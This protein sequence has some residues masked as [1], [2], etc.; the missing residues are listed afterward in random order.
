MVARQTSEGTLA[1]WCPSHENLGYRPTGTVSL[2]ETLVE[3][4]YNAPNWEGPSGACA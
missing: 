3:S 4:C 1:L 2:P